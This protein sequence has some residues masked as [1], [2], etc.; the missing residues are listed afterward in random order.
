MNN[1]NNKNN[2]STNNVKVTSVPWYE[3][4]TGMILDLMCKCTC[5]WLMGVRSV[6]V[7]NFTAVYWNRDD[8]ASKRIVQTVGGQDSSKFRWG[9]GWVGLPTQKESFACHWLDILGPWTILSA[10][11][12]RKS[13]YW[14]S[15]S[16]R[17]LWST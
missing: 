1:N 8:Y 3:N 13:P 7:W 10:V 14:V 6:Y 5:F 17:Y 2:N 4:K 16:S 12:K 15:S 11:V 9:K